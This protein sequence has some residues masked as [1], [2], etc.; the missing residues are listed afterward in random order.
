[1]PA[2]DPPAYSP[3]SYASTIY[4]PLVQSNTIRVLTLYPAISHDA[5]VQCGLLS[6]EISTC[7]ELEQSYAALSYV[8]GNLSDPRFVY[9]NEQEVYIG[10]NLFEALRHLRRRDRPIRLWADTLCI[11]QIDITERNHQV[12]RMR[13]IYSSALETV[14][15][16]GDDDRS[17]TA[18][19]A[20]NLLERQSE[21]ALN[22][23]GNEDMKLPSTLEENLIHFRGEVA[24]VELSVLQRPWFLRVWVLQEVVVSRKVSIQC[25]HRRI[26]WND[27]C[28]V[29]LLNPRYHDRCGYSM[30]A[31]ERVD[32][33]RD[34]FKA[35]CAYQESHDLARLR[36]SWHT[37]VT[38]YGSRSAHIID[39]LVRARQLEASD[40]RDKIF[41]LLGISTNVDVDNRLVAVDY[42][43]STAEVQTDLACYLIEEHKSLDMLSYVDHSINGFS[44]LFSFGQ[45]E[46]LPSWVPDWDAGQV[47]RWQR[48]KAMH[49]YD[50]NGDSLPLGTASPIIPIILSFF[51]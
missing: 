32:I 47:A 33:V 31:I 6:T 43:K 17:N 16:L 38:N 4:T 21:W 34:M 51:E 46:A 24:Y 45:A 28:N 18:S 2:D 3:P 10:R 11:K 14:I 44:S 30:Q 9:V 49:A 26:P 48:L 13:N 40:P 25:G 1:M 8:W 41:A 20:W 19:S 29:V 42:G 27:F 15:Y 50:I 36:P 7:Q 5:E 37:N 35:R 39:M 12:Y 22:R 23:N